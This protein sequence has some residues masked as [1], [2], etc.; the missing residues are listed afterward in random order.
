MKTPKD[1]DY[2]LW[3]DG[4]GKCFARVKSTGETTEVSPEVMRLL[5]SEEKALRREYENACVTD[6]DGNR[7]ARVLS[8]DSMLDADDDSFAP[9]TWMTSPDDGMDAALTLWQE[10]DFLKTLTEK[11]QR[12]YRLV[13]TEK[14]SYTESAALCGTSWQ[15]VQKDMEL[16]RKKAK[17]FFG[18]RV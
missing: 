14:Q 10:D 18:T 12:T 13:V 16:I 17:I 3:T 4:A 5:R 15:R 11:Q 2:D 7:H 6:E 8:L 9:E 1:F